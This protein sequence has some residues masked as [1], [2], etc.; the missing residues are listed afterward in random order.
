MSNFYI[1]FIYLINIM[2]NFMPQRPIDYFPLIIICIMIGM[3]IYNVS[4]RPNSYS[5]VKVGNNSDL[6]AV[7]K[8][9]TNNGWVLF[10]SRHCGWCIKQKEDLGDAMKNI[11][12]FDYE[13]NQ[14]LIHKYGEGAFP[15]WYNICNGEH[16]T[17][18]IENDRLSELNKNIEK[19][20]QKMTEFNTM[21]NKKH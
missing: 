18:Y 17:G 12:V 1:I 4:K 6:D 19:N 14:K 3:F 5:A 20:S 7:T 2:I 10:T 11:R 8:G 21:A 15:D 16:A 9:L 13:D